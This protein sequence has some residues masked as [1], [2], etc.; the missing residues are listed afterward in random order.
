MSHDA[1]AAPPLGRFDHVAIA[2]RPESAPAARR[3][4]TGVLGA[5]PGMRRTLSEFAFQHFHLDGVKL[6]VLW[7][8]TAESFLTR[9]L[10]QRGEGLHHITLTVDDLEG[11]CARLAGHDLRVVGK[12]TSNPEWMEAFLSPRSAF[13]VLFQ[14]AQ[15]GPP[16]EQD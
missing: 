14:L 7:P 6:E 5:R 4:M 12:N 1:S 8:T 15:P 3:F 10:E 16:S 11:S 2:V 13:G 9:F